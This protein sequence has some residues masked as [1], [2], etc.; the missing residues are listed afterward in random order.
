M[1]AV[2]FEEGSR[3][4]HK[5]LGNANNY[6]E[7]DCKRIVESPSGELTA[8]GFTNSAQSVK[9]FAQ[10]LTEGEWTSGVWHELPAEAIR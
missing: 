8:F 6:L 4:T 10:G 2:F 7:F 1:S 5:E 3:Y 9:W